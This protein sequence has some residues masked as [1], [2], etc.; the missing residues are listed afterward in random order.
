MCG[1]FYLKLLGPAVEEMLGL[2][3]TPDVHPRFNIAP[4]QQAL[5]ARTDES[6]RRVA[7]S[8]RWGLVPFW[9]DDESIGNKLIN[10]RSET[11]ASK[12]AFR[13]AFKHRRCV[14]PASGFYEWKV[15]DVDKRHKQPMAVR[16]SGVEGFAMA[17]LWETWTS[18]QD[19]EL[20]T[21]TILTRDAALEIREIHG[22]MPAILPP[23][24]IDDWLDPSNEDG[25]A[26]T[27]IVQRPCAELD[28][29]AVSKR[30]N[31]PRNDDPSLIE[32]VDEEPGT[33]FG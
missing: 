4:T 15:S 8:L 18:E 12:P 24:V 7:A 20:E 29:Y 14:I 23:G 1:R 28:A 27:E 32:P 3:E 2:D 5:V 17:G 25:A 9:A 13:A 6:G 31:T 16:L 11:A 22:R 21:F 30:V 26:L 33:L 19:G 10:A